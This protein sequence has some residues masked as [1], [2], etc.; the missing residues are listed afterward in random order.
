MEKNTLESAL[1]EFSQTSGTNANDV[2][3]FFALM[4]DG[5]IKRM[6]KEDMATVLGEL[7]GN[8]LGFKRVLTGNDNMDNIEDGIYSSVNEDD[9]NNNYS[10]NTMY[11]QLTTPSRKDIWQFAL[12]AN[13][14]G[15]AVRKKKTTGWSVW[16]SIIN[17]D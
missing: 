16:K 11:I 8:P 9:P 2:K 1:K 14:L 10:T 15:I 7:L 5:S 3:E 12:S 4:S 17:I 13:A 6:P